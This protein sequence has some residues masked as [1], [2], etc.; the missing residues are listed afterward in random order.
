MNTHQS[1]GP[2]LRKSTTLIG[3]HMGADFHKNNFRSLYKMEIYIFAV[4][5]LFFWKESLCC[6][7]L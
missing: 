2:S 1:Y 5:Y 6:N 4:S 3:K 7:K